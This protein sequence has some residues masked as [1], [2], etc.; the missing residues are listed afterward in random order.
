MT[1]ALRIYRASRDMNQTE[2]AAILGCSQGMVSQYEKGRKKI[3]A[4]K[5]HEY[6]EKTGIPL[7]KLRPDI[8][9]RYADETVD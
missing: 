5:C 6:S 9:R 2:L 1:K 3:P 7:Y 4:E 8:F